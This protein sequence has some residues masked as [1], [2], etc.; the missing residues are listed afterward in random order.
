MLALVLEFTAVVAWFLWLYR[1]QVRARREAN[2][3]PPDQLRLPFERDREPG[4]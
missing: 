4:E 3:P 1:R 2:R